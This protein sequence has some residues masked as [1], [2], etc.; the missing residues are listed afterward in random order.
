MFLFRF[1]FYF[2]LVIFIL[3]AILMLLL[4]VFMRR[5]F[6][7]KPTTK[8]GDFSTNSNGFK[9]TQKKKIIEKNEGDY[10]DYEEVK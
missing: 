2:F 3:G 4:K 8:N 7:R 10:V 6:G 5:T 1:I 9:S